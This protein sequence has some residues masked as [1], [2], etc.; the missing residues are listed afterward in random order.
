MRHRFWNAELANDWLREA[1]YALVEE[2]Y[3]QSWIEQ[4]SGLNRFEEIGLTSQT[5][6]C[7]PDSR[8]YIY[9]S[10]P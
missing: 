8:I 2:R 9:R 10:L 3:H 5:V 6:E 1:E 4:T 7:R